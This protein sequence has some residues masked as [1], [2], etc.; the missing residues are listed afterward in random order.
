MDYSPFY[1][2]AFPLMIRGVKVTMVTDNH[3][4]KKNKN[5]Y[6]YIYFNNKH[7][8]VMWLLNILKYFMISVLPVQQRANRY[9]ILSVSKGKNGC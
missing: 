3:Q 7:L 4:T 8:K 2:N 9:L 5:S 1:K 6:I